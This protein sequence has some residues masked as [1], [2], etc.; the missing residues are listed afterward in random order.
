MDSASFNSTTSRCIESLLLVFTQDIESTINEITT[1]KI[2]KS[3]AVL[4][5]FI[6][7]VFCELQTHT[8]SA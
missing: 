1:Q 6:A 4:N 2:K 5:F 8:I 3:I 7:I